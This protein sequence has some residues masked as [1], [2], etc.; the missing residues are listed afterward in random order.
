M[1]KIRDGSIKR[2][3]LVPGPGQGDEDVS[4]EKKGG[5]DTFSKKRG[6]QA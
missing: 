1:L 4:L 3:Y 6:G 2:I 5:E